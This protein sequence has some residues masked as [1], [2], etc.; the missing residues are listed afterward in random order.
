MAKSLAAGRGRQSEMGRKRRTEISVTVV[1]FGREHLMLRVVDP[2]TGKQHHKTAG[3]ANP[4]EA[5]RR[6]GEWEKELKERKFAPI[7]AISWEFFWQRYEDEHLR[8]LAVGTLNRATVTFNRVREHL[9]PVYLVD[10]QTPQ[11]LALY[12]KL[13][14]AG[15]SPASIAS[16]AKILGGALRWAKSMKLISEVPDIPRPARSKEQKV[17]KGRAITAAEFETMLDAT[18]RVVSVDDAPYWRFYLRGLWTGGLRLDES[19]ELWWDDR[20]RLS[21]D[22]DHPRPM[23]RIPAELEKGHTD[24]IL[25]MA[26]E[27]A[28]LLATVPSERRKGPVFYLPRHRRQ[29][30]DRPSHWWVSRVVSDIGEKAEIVVDTKGRTKYASAHD[31]RRSFG[32]RWSQLVMPAVLMELMRHES[33]ETT[34]RFYVGRSAQET[35]EILYTA[36][37]GNISGNR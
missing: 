27:F 17:M 30:R 24:R 37:K 3:T 34:M 36:I 12:A 33:I 32:D 28:D 23:L 26:P 2:L 4:K 29:D 15:L 8:S 31:L 13:R 22:F 19:L 16:D 5:E 6:A 7:D 11:I 10:I 25:P 21:I 14:K 18:E 9:G 20:S 35:T 1:D